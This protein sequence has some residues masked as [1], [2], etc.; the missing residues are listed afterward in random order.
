M[1]DFVCDLVPPVLGVDQNICSGTE[2]GPVPIVS[3]PTGTGTITYQWQ[4]SSTDC[5]G[6][7]AD[8]AGET[9]PTFNP[10]VITTDRFYSCLLYTS[11]SPRD[12]R[13]SRMPSSA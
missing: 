9:N 2:P 6:A 1:S 12:Q 3:G 4:E 13:G 7:F 10:P 8:L 5:N 11:P